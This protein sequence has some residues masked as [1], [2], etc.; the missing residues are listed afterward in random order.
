MKAENWFS[1]KLEEYKDDLE[2]RTEG[3][4]LEFNEK[5]VARMAEMNISRT[6]LAKRL[7][8]SKAFVTKLLNG[9]PNLTVKTMMSISDALGCELK[10]D[11][12]P[13]QL[14]S[15]FRKKSKKTEVL[16]TSQLSRQTPY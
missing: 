10:L 3:V 5:I 14:R 7:R 2:F 4:I 11:I 8:V 15:T 13:M 6:E 12:Y 16:P 1:K 9:N